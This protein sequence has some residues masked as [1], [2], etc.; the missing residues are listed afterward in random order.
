MYLSH[1][2]HPK[3]GSGVFERAGDTPMHTMFPAFLPQNVHVFP[4]K[5]AHKIQP[6]HE[7]SAKLFFLQYVLKI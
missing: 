6:K 5:N 3:R 2:V 4:L 1:S 7:K